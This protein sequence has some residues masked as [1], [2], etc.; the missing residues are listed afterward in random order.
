MRIHVNGESREVAEESSLQD[1]VEALKL[2]PERLAI[3]LNQSVVR[4]TD[5]PTTILKD[6]DRVEIVQFVSGGL[7]HGVYPV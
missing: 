3:E 6:D 1:L 5:R 2:A 4:R 7:I